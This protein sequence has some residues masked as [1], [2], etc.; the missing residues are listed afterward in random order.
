MEPSFE[1]YSGET[2]MSELEVLQLAG[3]Q[4]RAIALADGVPY[5]LSSAI[6]TY[7]ALRVFDQCERAR[8]VNAIDSMLLGGSPPAPTQ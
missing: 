3:R 6:A 2:E 5:R 1:L 7:R 4:A 8:R